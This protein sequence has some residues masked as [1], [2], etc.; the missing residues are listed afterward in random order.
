MQANGHTTVW[1]VHIGAGRPHNVKAWYHDLKGWWAA[2]RMARQ[3]SRNATLKAS[4]DAKREAV[5]PLHADAA[6]DLLTS[7]QAFSS[8]AT[9]CHL[10][11]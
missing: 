7:T 5:S 1:G 11:L 4:W 6:V 8:T 3:E 9:L 2:Y 10:A